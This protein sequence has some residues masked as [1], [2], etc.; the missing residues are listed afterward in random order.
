MVFYSLYIPPTFLLKYDD[1]FPLK[2]M[3]FEGMEFCVP[4]NT[5]YY[6]YSLY[7]DYMLFP[8]YLEPLHSDEVLDKLKNKESFRDSF[9]LVNKY[10][11][12]E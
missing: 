11:V 6:L 10:S 2:K 9:E 4:N 1:V 5:E 12:R 7:G 8:D 3:E